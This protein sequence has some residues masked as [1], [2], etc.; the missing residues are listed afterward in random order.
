MTIEPFTEI[1]L[2]SLDGLRPEGWSDIKLPFLFYLS[3]P[4][5]RPL[6][7]V[8]DGTV[9]G[10]GV[11]IVFGATA[12]LAHIIVR[13][14]SRGQGIGGKIVARLIEILA[15]AGV[16][17]ISLTATDLGRP[18]YK[19]AGF[20]DQIEYL[21]YAREAGERKVDPD[22]RIIPCGPALKDSV[23]ALDRESSGEE[24]GAAVAERLDGAL[25]FVM[26]GEA[27]GFYAPGIG[28]GLVIGRDVE[29]GLALLKL[30]SAR[31]Q[32]IA[33]PA[34]NE[35]GRQFLVANGY[36]EVMRFWRMVWGPPFPWKPENIYSRVAGNM[37]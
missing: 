34:G 2:P 35:T 29:A 10:T 30:R 16:R 27:R 15:A 24:R 4:F 5:C 23:L 22:G 33:L 12:W 7:A 17:T 14:E 25:V 21:H 36:R 28:E 37:G 18:V 13:P 26:G 8:V 6:K 1:D 32:R 3:H 31:E 9:A 11:G 19:K 20:V